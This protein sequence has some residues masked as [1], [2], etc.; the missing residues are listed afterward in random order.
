MITAV[1][2][3]E[4]EGIMAAGPLSVVFYTVVSAAWG[5]TIEACKSL[6]KNIMTAHGSVAFQLASMQ[7]GA[8]S[9]GTCE[10]ST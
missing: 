2:A 3:T 8:S 10:T 9:H 5:F 7:K 1:P 4:F 6:T